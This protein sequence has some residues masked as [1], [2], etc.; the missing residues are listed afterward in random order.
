MKR[1][2]RTISRMSTST[3]N[4]SIVEHIAFHINTEKIKEIGYVFPYERERHMCVTK[5]KR[6]CTS[7][8]NYSVVSVRASI[9]TER[10]QER[11]HL[12][13]YRP[14][15]RARYDHRLSLPVLL[16]VRPPF[17]IIVSPFSE[18]FISIVVDS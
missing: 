8:L 17:S 2:I 11:E 5:Y 18:G 14:M 12:R 6:P 7:M 3:R 4:N 16:P 10:A 15:L 9:H 13:S 1:F